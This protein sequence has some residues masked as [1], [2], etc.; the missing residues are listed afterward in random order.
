MFLFTLLMFSTFSPIHPD[1]LHRYLGHAYFICWITESPTF[2]IPNLKKNISSDLSFFTYFFPP[3]LSFFTY[4]F[5]RRW[6]LSLIVPQLHTHVKHVHGNQNHVRETVYSA[7][8]VAEKAILFSKCP[9]K[10]APKRL[11]FPSSLV[12]IW[13]KTCYMNK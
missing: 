10:K 9:S 11:D 3:D 7:V 2:K 13:N 5:P 4:F 12:K 8:M 1:K 6:F